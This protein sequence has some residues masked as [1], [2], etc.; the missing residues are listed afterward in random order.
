LLSQVFP[1][2]GDRIFKNWGMTARV[3]VMFHPMGLGVYQ[4][5][6]AQNEGEFCSKCFKHNQGLVTVP[7][8][9]K[10]KAQQPAICEAKM[11]WRLG[12]SPYKQTVLGWSLEQF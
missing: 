7:V 10:Q 12:P 11:I 1:D 5:T 4:I 9:Q 8:K 2:P 3:N 6:H